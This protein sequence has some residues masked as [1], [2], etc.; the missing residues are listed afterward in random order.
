[1]DRAQPAR[2]LSDRLPA[3]PDRAAAILEELRH[4]DSAELRVHSERSGLPARH[5]V[6]GGDP[7]RP[8]ARGEQRR[9][10]SRRKTPTRRRLP[11]NRPNAVE[12]KQ[13]ELRAE[14]DIAVGRLRERGDGSLREAFSDSPGGVDVLADVERRIQRE[15]TRDAHQ[16]QAR[17][18]GAQCDAA[19]SMKRCHELAPVL[20]RKNQE[21]PRARGTAYAA[22]A[23]MV[24][25]TSVPS[26]TSL[27]TVRWPPTSSARSRMPGRPKCPGRWSSRTAGAIPLPSSRTRT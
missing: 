3:K 4:I 24:N 13:A 20:S 11:R 19:P 9:D 22:A 7:Q 15:R 5:A 1:A 26:P 6:E 25:S 23:G 10:V 2:Q 8:V 16:Q 12:A 17:Q 18:R 27:H 14:P 21:R